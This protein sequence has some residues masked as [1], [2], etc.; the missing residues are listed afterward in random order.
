MSDFCTA[1]SV[2]F[3]NMLFLYALWAFVKNGSAIVIQKKDDTL[4]EMFLKRT[5]IT[6]GLYLIL[7]GTYKFGVVRMIPQDPAHIT[8]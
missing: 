7:S 1:S 6:S 3:I 5:Q 8:K 4:Y 2:F